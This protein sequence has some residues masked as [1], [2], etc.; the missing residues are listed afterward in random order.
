MSES[1]FKINLK[2]NVDALYVSLG[3]RKEFYIT[4]QNLTENYIPQ[5]KVMLS[6]PPQVKI[7]SK[8][9]WYGGIAK[10]LTKSRLFS[11]LIKENGV[12]D[13]TATL[14]TKKGHNIT[15]PFIAQVGTTQAPT[16]TTSLLSKPIVEKPVSNVN[17]PYCHTEMSEDVKFCPHCGSNVEE[18]LKEIQEKKSV[19]QCPNCGVELQEEAKFCAKCGQ[20]V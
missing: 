11:I 16:K 5:V 18:K 10:H 13:L 12:Y 17:C 9:E 4:V 3:K 19:N 20:K 15:L 14:T 8:S 1:D 2:G 7:Y 6:G